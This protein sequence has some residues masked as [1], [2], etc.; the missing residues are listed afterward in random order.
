[1]YYLAKLLHLKDFR[2]E[3]ITESDL[4]IRNSTMPKRKFHNAYNRN[5][6]FFKIPPESVRFWT[7]P[8]GDGL[9]EGI[10]WHKRKGSQISEKLNGS[11]TTFLNK[12]INKLYLFIAVLGSQ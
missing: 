8:L 11:T 3:N 12:K 6:C 9:L 10:M 7:F 1:M 2:A 5:H 4:E